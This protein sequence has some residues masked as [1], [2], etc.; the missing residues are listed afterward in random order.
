MNAENTNKPSPVLLYGLA[1]VA[2]AGLVL[3][4]VVLAVGVIQ[5]EQANS[6]L[7]GLLF[8]GGLALLITGAAGWV[9]VVQPQRHFDDINQP[10]E[11]DHV[12]GHAEEHAHDEHEAVVHHG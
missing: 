7:M 4:I 11:S 8:T 2:G 10:A 1:M 3:M 9:F 6:S 12:H 5:G